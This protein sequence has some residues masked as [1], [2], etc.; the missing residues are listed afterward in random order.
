M[1]QEYH[2]LMDYLNKTRVLEQGTQE[3]I[4]QAK[5]E[6]RRYYM[7]RYKRE[8][9]GNKQELVLSIPKNFHKSLQKEARR[10]GLSIPRFVVEIIRGYLESIP[11]IHHPNQFAILE[12]EVARL[13]SELQFI[14]DQSFLNVVSPDIEQLKKRLE[15]IE[16]EIVKVSHGV[17]L[18]DFIINFLT[19]NPELKPTLIEILIEIKN[20]P[21]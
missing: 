21:S 4:D 8:Q 15:V 19:L 12:T 3:E 20:R 11:V 16:E 10:H 13:L 7:R 6:Y 2:S 18:K 9:R 17:P 1:E 14:G 5:K